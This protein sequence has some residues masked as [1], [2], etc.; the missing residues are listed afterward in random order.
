[1]ER[2]LPRSLDWRPVAFVA[3]VGVNLGLVIYFQTFPGTSHPDWQLWEAM[4]TR[5]MYDTG[6]LAPFV[7]SPVAGWIMSLVPLIGVWVWAALHVAALLLLRDWRLIA[8]AATTWGFWDELAGG[9]TM[10]F[11]FVAGVLALRGNRAAAVGYF[12]LFFLMPRPLMLPLAAWLLWRDRSITVPVAVVGVVLGGLSLASG[13]VPEWIAAVLRHSG[14]IGN[15]A[16]SAFVG[17]APWLMLGVPVGVW[18]ALRGHFGWAGLAVSPYW[19][20]HYLLLPLWDLR[21][22]TQAGTPPLTVRTWPAL[23]MGSRE[24]VAAPS[25]SSS[26]VRTHQPL[27]PPAVGSRRKYRAVRGAARSKD[28]SPA[29]SPLLSS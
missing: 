8:L 14:P 18:L 15:L 10:T 6:T 22:Y 4:R 25:S 29:A 26:T 19:L 17:T 2:A 16:P 20:A 12:A 3:Y 27:P 1:M 21:G 23:P 13:L 28:W 7:W 11:V 24:I 9:N 5:P